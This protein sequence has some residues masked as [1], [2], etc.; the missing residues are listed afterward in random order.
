VLLVERGDFAAALPELLGAWRAERDVRLANVIDGVS[1]K[2]ER[3]PLTTSTQRATTDE[4]LALVKKK[5]PA[6]FGR[7]AAVIGT[8]R[9][10]FMVDMLEALLADWPADPRLT[11]RAVELLKRPP[12]SGSAT[13]S[14]WRRLFK[15]LQTWADPRVVTLLP[16]IDFASLFPAHAPGVD[17]FAAQFFTDRVGA[18]VE[19]VKKKNAKPAKGAAL[20]EAALKRLEALVNDEGTKQLEQSA[21]AGDVASKAVLTDLLL[22]KNDARGR[23]VALEQARQVRSL[24]VDEVAEMKALVDANHTRWCGALAPVVLPGTAK[25]ESGL[26]VS[27]SLD[28][29]KRKVIESLKGDPAWGSLREVFVYEAPLELLRDPVMRSLRVVRGLSSESGAAFLNWDSGLPWTGFGAYLPRWHQNE[30]AAD[31][32]L[33]QRRLLKTFP[34]LEELW[35]SAYLLQPAALAW[36]WALP[37]KRIGF[38]GLAGKN[39]GAWFDAALAQKQAFELSTGPFEGL[40]VAVDETRTRVELR[41]KGLT[42]PR[43]L[44]WA[45]LVKAVSP[46]KGKIQRLEISGRTTKSEWA[47]LE[48]LLASGGVALT[49]G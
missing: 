19:A 35:L 24:T 5:D 21:R 31:V 20:D 34:K 9:S 4:F 38:T 25:F 7:L 3:P 2:I 43:S 1:L 48:G 27:C 37:L 29:N 28:H 8:T 14:A 47:A 40:R 49:V 26:L 13:Q 15:A 42:Q 44:T 23:L 32:E 17:A 11:T 16:A 12:F 22:E 33:M 30:T 6:D 45:E 36:A 41:V 18:V 10:G 39:V 46:L